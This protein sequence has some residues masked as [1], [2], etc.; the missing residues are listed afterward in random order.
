MNIKPVF[1]KEIFFKSGLKRQRFD[2]HYEFD[3]QNPPA[4]L[5]DV[6]KIKLIPVDNKSPE[7]EII[8]PAGTKPVLTRF[9]DRECPSGKIVSIRYLIG[10]N[11]NGIRNYIA[12][13][14]DLNRVYLKC[15]T[16]GLK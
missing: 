10:W 12:Y 11:K 9:I 15:D 2:E 5:G 4:S 6:E 16:D 14:P 3:P 8:I 7:F 13:D 1:L